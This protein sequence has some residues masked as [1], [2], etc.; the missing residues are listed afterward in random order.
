MKQ[1]VTP[2]QRRLMIELLSAGKI[3]EV[4][5]LQKQLG[6]QRT[7]TVKRA[8]EAGRRGPSKDFNDPRWK[9]AIERGPV[10]A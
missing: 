9:W 8:Y 6:V 3:A 2:A 1:K 10:I 4:R 7:Y 5:A